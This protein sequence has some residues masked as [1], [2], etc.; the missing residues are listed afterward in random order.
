MDPFNPPAYCGDYLSRFGRP[1]QKNKSG[2][3]DGTFDNGEDGTFDNG[4]H[5]GTFDSTDSHFLSVC[6]YWKAVNLGMTIAALELLD[7]LEKG[8]KQH[9]VARPL[10]L[11]T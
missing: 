9:G 8:T 4:G 7:R 3:Y 5:D 2:G 6:L 11:L 10:G 1:H